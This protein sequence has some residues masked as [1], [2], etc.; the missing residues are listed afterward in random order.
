ML[1]KEDMIYSITRNYFHV[2]LFGCFLLE[3]AEGCLFVSLFLC[4]FVS[5]QRIDKE[6]QLLSRSY[7]IFN[8]KV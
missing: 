7:L 8:K 2:Y 4:F 5:F 6:V 1:T 3:H